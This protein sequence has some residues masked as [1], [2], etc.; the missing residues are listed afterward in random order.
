MKISA[1][2]LLLL[3]A[4]MNSTASFA[5]SPK[6][7]SSQGELQVEAKITEVKARE[8]ALTKVPKGTIKSSELEKERG[9]LIWSIDVA[10]VGTVNITEVQVDAKTGAIIAV[11]IETP[12]DQKK[13]RDMD[14]APGKEGNRVKAI[15]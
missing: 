2:A 1:I 14:K 3:I 13:E 9:R 10:T 15:P 12:E 5:E 7:E 11:E 4:G 6:H 8:I